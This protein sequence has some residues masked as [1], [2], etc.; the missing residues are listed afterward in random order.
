MSTMRCACITVAAMVISSPVAAQ[1]A[2][3]NEA[4]ISF[5]H[6]HLSVADAELH[7]ALWIDLFDAEVA[8]T[9]GF[10]AVR[11]PGALV[12]FAEQAPT[13]PSVGTA[14]NHFGFKVQDL[15]AVLA[16][17]RALGYEVDAEFMGGEGLPQAYITMPNGARVELTGDPEISTT[18][19]MHHVHFYSSA[20]RD[21]LSW[22]RNMFGGTHRVRGTIET[23]LDVPGTNLSFSDSEETVSPTQGTAVDHVGFEVEDIEAFAE[24]LRSKGVEFLAEPFYV[25]SLDTWVAFFADPAGALVEISQ[26]LDRY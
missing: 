18:A 4:G 21:V 23:T 12:F 8:E 5:S 24:V 1:I 3:P 26:G 19:E 11:L 16:K 20:Y 17:W 13:A 10:A 14:V 22:Y 7:T 9:A 6:V 2:D 25:E 15:A